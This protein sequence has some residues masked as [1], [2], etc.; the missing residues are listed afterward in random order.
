[1]TTFTRW[2]FETQSSHPVI[3]DIDTVKKSRNE[4]CGHGHIFARKFTPE[5]G[6]YIAMQCSKN[7][8]RIIYVKKDLVGRLGNQMF[9]YASTLGIAHYIEQRYKIKTKVCITM[10]IEDDPLRKRKEDIDKVCIGPFPKCRNISKTKFKVISEQGSGI[11]DIDRF[12]RPENVEIET[13]MD[14]GF[15]QSWK[16]FESIKDEIRE[17]FRFDEKIEK[18]AKNYLKKIKKR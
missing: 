13:D 16:Y 14:Q 10:D 7:T 3:F 15:L 5:A 6:E 9:Q 1:M 11:Y 17:I 8:P 4:I 18:D 2:D 12:I